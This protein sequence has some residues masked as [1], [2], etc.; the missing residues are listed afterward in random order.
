MFETS[1]FPSKIG[2]SLKNFEHFKKSKV[3]FFII[4]EN[5][6]DTDKGRYNMFGGGNSKQINNKWTFIIIV[7]IT[8]ILTH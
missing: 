6:W 5:T 1:M 2:S 7:L 4:T 3:H 8:L